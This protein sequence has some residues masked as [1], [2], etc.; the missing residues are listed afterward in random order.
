MG[1]FTSEKEQKLLESEAEVSNTE[2]TNAD[3]L[4]FE[5]VSGFSDVTA[6]VR[7]KKR[8]RKRNLLDM[9]SKTRSSLSVSLR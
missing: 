6:T 1:D 7:K 4:N 8:N 5:E 2:D 9:T 3:E